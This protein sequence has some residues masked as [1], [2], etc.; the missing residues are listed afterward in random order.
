MSKQYHE[1][2]IETCTTT[3]RVDITALQSGKMRAWPFVVKELKESGP[4]LVK[5]SEV[6]CTYIFIRAEHDFDI[7]EDS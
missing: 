6:E 3:T 5:D 1:C 2:D 4:D 7:D